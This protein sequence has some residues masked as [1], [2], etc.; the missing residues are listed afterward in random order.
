[1]Y[2]R[3][4][5]LS[6]R[7]AGGRALLRSAVCTPAGRRALRLSFAG[8]LPAALR[9]VSLFLRECLYA[10]ARAP[11]RAVAALGRSLRGGRA[12]SD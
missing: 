10:A 9:G 4:L 12:A 5:L 7:T 3:R 8:A 6:P 1:M 11:L 2:A